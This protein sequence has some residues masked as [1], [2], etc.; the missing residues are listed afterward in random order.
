MGLANGDITQWWLLTGLL[1]LGNAAVMT[2]LW[3]AG[4]T[5]TFDASRGL[6]M[7]VALAGMGLWRRGCGRYWRRA[8]STGS[9]GGWRF[10]AM[11][12]SWAAVVLPLTVLFFKPRDLPA[13]APGARRRPDPPPLGPA[14]RSR[15]FV[16]ILVAGSLFA[17]CQLSLIVHLV[18]IL[19][20]KG[21]EMSTTQ[22]RSPGSPACSRCSAACAPAG[23]WICCR[24]ARW[25]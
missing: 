12:L 3:V 23:C 20:A 13:P 1:S 22:P 6:A 16:C 17:F 18:A 19:R 4:T 14:L 25:R 8:T 7:G 21:I 9:A 5:R 11:A 24:C 15:A 10:P 2:T